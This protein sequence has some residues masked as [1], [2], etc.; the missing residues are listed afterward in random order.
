MPGQGVDSTERPVPQ[1]LDGLERI[2][3]V[4]ASGFRREALRRFVRIGRWLEPVPGVVCRTNG[5]LTSRQ[6]RRAAMLYGGSGAVLSHDSA[7]EAF[8]FCRPVDIVHVTVPHGRN[9]RST[10]EVRVHQ[11]TRPTRAVVV[12]ELRVT[13]PARTAIDMALR[14]T[15]PDDVAALLGRAMQRWPLTVEELDDELALAPMRGSRPARDALADIA[16]GSRSAAEAKL[17]RL[18]RSSTLPMP[19][20]NAPVS[21]SLGTRY[22]DAL[23]RELGK[24]VEVDG[25]AFHLDAGA[26]RADL[27]RQNAVQTAGIVLL[28]IAAR[29]LWTEPEAVLAEIAAFLGIDLAATA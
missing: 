20:F 7:G 17:V 13:A 16:A 18:L 6:W 28:R 10:A 29:R 9:L 12:D 8:G 3:V 11:T 1:W 22:V 14:L 19:E 24:G 23:W 15:R 4:L 21:T 26:W 27:T 25:Q 2:D 5:I